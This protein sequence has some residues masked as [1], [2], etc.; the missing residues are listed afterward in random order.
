MKKKTALILVTLTVLVG[1]VVTFY[2]T[3]MLLSDVSNMF[4]GVHDAYIVSSIPAFMLAV[5]FVAFLVFVMRYYRYP[6]YRKSMGNLYSIYLGVNSLVG[7]AFCILTG[8]I[9]GSFTMPYPFWAYDVIMMIVHAGLLALAVVL[10]VKNRKMQ[11]ADQTKKKIQPHY[12]IYSAVLG[13]MTYFAFNKFG[14]LILSPLYVYMRSLY[15]TWPF[16]LSLLCPIALVVHVLVY[17]FDGYKGKEKVGIAV[18]STVFALS[19]GLG[20]S[21][22]I[23]GSAHTQFISAVSPALPLERLATMPINS[24]FQLVAMVLFSGYYLWYAVRAYK[25]AKAVNNESN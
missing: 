4:Y 7:I 16:Y 17:F 3:N 15:L 12:V 22:L 20:V 8:V 14:A 10:N 5:D 2:A 6:A 25:L 18:V 1:S 13:A 21:V 24:I 11:L 23:I 19:L 9:Y